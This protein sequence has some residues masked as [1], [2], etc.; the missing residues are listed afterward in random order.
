MRQVLKGD[1][2]A[3]MPIMA[4]WAV[5]FLLWLT[6]GITLPDGIGY[7]QYLPSVIGGG[8]L[9]F[10]DEWAKAG[11]ID[12]EGRVLHEQ[13]QPSGMVGNHWTVGPAVAWLPG[14]L[15]GHAI[16]PRAEPFALTR[17]LP[18]ILGSAV[19]GLLALLLSWLVARRVAPD[20][21]TLATLGIWLGSPLL[22]YSLRNGV[23]A[24]AMGALCGALVLW[25]ALRLRDRLDPLRAMAFGLAAG[26]AFAVR[27][28]NAPFALVGLLVL[29]V[30]RW[31]ELARWPQIARL[32]VPALIGALIGALPQLIVSIAIY[33]TPW[34]FL[35]FGG[36]DGAAF[37][38]FKRVWLW[39]LLLSWYHGMLPWTP[40][41]GLA[42]A[43]MYWL[44]RRDAGIG[45]AALYCVATQWAINACLERVFWGGYAFGQRRFDNCT[46]F[47]V[48]A[49]AALL[50]RL[51][52]WI[53]LISV[54]A[55]CAW[56][57]LLMLSTPR[58]DLNAYQS[59]SRL[60]EAMGEMLADP[61]SWLQPMG[62]VPAGYRLTVIASGLAFIAAVAGIGWLLTRARPP[63]REI[64]VTIVAVAW[65]LG[66]SGLLLRAASA[67]PSRL[68]EHAELIERN[69]AIGA[70]AGAVQF[71]IGLLRE[72]VAWLEATG[73]S[74]EAARTRAEMD[75]LERKWSTPSR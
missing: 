4:A 71:R 56:T 53:G 51:P 47:F 12:A 33:G 61:S 38:A 27:P 57:T 16:A 19:A 73:R 31:R 32:A 72:E 9:A 5:A 58:F 17:V 18:A 75:E 35:R 25:T 60:L 59:P 10:H 43:G 15:V 29:D 67:S 34:G 52:R 42:L 68:A 49:L 40:V 41:L 14:F 8:D 37:T 2:R 55:C 36:G 50:A 28:Q 48:L 7:L 54:I 63:R 24:H 65:L 13:I 1:A 26:Y 46:V 11:L 45:R 22:F 21:A 44:W 66:A 64:I 20:H 30:A 39:E 6:P 23:T 74:E 69:R 3:F 62:G 70:E